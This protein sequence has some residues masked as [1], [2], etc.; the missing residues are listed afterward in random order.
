M[1]G[2]PPSACAGITAAARTAA[3]G[4]DKQHR[5]ALER[6][7]WKVLVVHSTIG[8]LA[9]EEDQLH[10]G[11]CTSQQCQPPHR[12]HEA[13]APRL[14][15]GAKGWRGA[16]KGS[17]TLDGCGIWRRCGCLGDVN[18][19]AVRGRRPSTRRPK[20]DNKSLPGSTRA[21]PIQIQPASLSLCPY[22]NN[23]PD[24]SH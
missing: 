9:H 5:L 7:R 13:T 20:P 15:H 11:S 17:G 18:W 12:L 14:R 4:A 8:I 3:A 2:R 22:S 19:A 24:T 1:A 10:H 23:E 6:P 21:G 16:G